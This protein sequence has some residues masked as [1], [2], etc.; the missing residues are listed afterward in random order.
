MAY[1]RGGMKQMA[2]S[3]TS[4][5]KLTCMCNVSWYSQVHGK[6]PEARKRWRLGEEWRGKGCEWISGWMLAG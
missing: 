2:G 1:E 6:S 4:A 3:P 5:T